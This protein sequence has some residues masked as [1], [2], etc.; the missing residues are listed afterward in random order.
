RIYIDTHRR[1][2]FKSEGTI[3]WGFRPQ[4]KSQRRLDGRVLNPCSLGSRASYLEPALPP[5][6]CLS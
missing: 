4:R 6:L 1:S 2:I 5:A 3:E